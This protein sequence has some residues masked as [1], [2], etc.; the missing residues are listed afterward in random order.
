MIGDWRLGI[1]LQSL[2]SDLSC[3]MADFETLAN[4][5]R[6]RRSVRRFRPD[7]AVAA[8]QVERLLDLAVWAPSPHNRQP[9]RFAV[10][11]D[12][13]AKDRLAR[14]M[15]ERLRSDRLRDGDD[16]A[17]VEADAA[18]SHARLTGA[19][20][21]I[22]VCLSLEGMDSYPDER[23]EQAERAMAMQSVA[24]AGE[25]L[26]LAAHAAGLGA[27][28]LCA[29]LFA[30]DT[31]REALHLAPDWE[32]Q[33]AVLLGVPVEPPKPRPR[34]AVAEVVLSL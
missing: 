23:R 24:M 31:V 19:P 30:P 26:L 2:I 34:R 3:Q 25:N 17:D 8:E 14:A 33:G 15:G 9:W 27:C 6:S 28:W 21:V 16:P 29:P 7:I 4:I 11:R 20:V 10:V 32:P 18:R 5:I 12:P 13:A 22:V 1:H